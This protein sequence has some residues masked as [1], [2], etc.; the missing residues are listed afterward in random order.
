MDLDHQGH[1][2][3]VDEKVDVETIIHI[4]VFM[5]WQRWITAD[6]SYLVDPLNLVDL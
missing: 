3:G 4:K 1:P 6:Y 5:Y 2:T